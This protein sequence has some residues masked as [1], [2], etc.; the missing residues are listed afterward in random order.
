MKVKSIEDLSIMDC[1]IKENDST[2]PFFQVADV[3]N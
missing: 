1:D 3:Y 2:F